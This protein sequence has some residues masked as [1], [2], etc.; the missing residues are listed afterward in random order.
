MP[1]ESGTATTWVHVLTWSYLAL[2]WIV[3]VVMIPVVM[4]KKSP[5]AA[6]AWLMVIFF[7]PLVG[8]F[9]YLLIGE[10]HLGRKRLRRR[11]AAVERIRALRPMVELDG[12]IAAAQVPQEQRDLTRLTQT[13]SDMR[14]LGGNT[15]ELI[16]D[17]DVFLDRLVEA[18]D[19]AEHSAHLEYYIYSSD[20]SGQRVSAALIRAAARGVRCRLLV[21]AAGSRAFLKR[22][23]GELRRAGVSVTASMP[24][25][26]LRALLARIDLRNHRKIA[27]IDNRVAFTGSQ[28]IINADYGSRRIGAWRDLSVRIEG[29]AAFQLQRV[30]LEDWTAERPNEQL[31]FGT[32]PMTPLLVGDVSIQS[33]PSGPGAENTAFSDLLLACINEAQ[34]RLVMTTPYFVPDEPIMASLRVAALRGV[35]VELVIP[36]K[37]NHPL[38]NAAAR[39]YFG[40]LIDA[41][42]RVRLHTNG[43]L[44]AKTLAVDDAFTLI[45][46]GNFDIRSFTLN[47]ELMQL[48]FGAEAV[49]ELERFHQKCIEESKPLPQAQ[50][51][52]RGRLARLGDEFARLLSP[53]L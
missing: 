53:L 46:S 27:V 7:E 14:A 47:F 50:W 41:G 13:V 6:M 31:D 29:P 1:P 5:Q 28:N 32:A 48:F 33:A 11:L 51:R 4:R 19:A 8:V 2:E 3:R 20:E 23:A 30:F 39:S 25:S 22:G 44:H 52:S 26:L 37:G 17:T 49:R 18:I 24:V 12:A 45:G 38:V 35:R 43:L 15:I 21:D 34:E 16:D 42:I 10:T 9:F 40:A 36:E